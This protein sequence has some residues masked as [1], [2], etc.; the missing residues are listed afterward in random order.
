[1]FQILEIVVSKTIVC[2]E[3]VEIRVE[4]EGFEY[5]VD[6]MEY[7]VAIVLIYEE[8][9]VWVDFDRVGEED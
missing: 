5:C 1:M 8:G 3:G 4:G 6:A 2:G 7:W 9:S